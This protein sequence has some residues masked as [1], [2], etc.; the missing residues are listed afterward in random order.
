MDENLR[1]NILPLLTTKNEFFE[2]VN[3]IIGERGE[4]NK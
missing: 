3:E 4:E 2:K 1:I